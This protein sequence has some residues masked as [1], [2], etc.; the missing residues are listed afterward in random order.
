MIA[1]VDTNVLRGMALEN[2]PLRLRRSGAAEV[3]PVQVDPAQEHLA[4][5]EAL[6]LGFEEGLRQGRAEGV[7]AGR[8]EGL[9]Q[10]LAEARL[11][12][13]Q[14]AEDAVVEAQR[15]L[16]EER[17]QLRELTGSLERVFDDC[18]DKCE[19]EMLALCY[20]TICRMVGAAAIQPEL[21]RVQVAHLVS[22]C[23]AD[24]P[25]SILVHP[26]DAELLRSEEA[27]QNA[28]GRMH[29]I[30]DAEVPLGGCIVKSRAGSLDLR[31]ETMLSACKSSLLGVRAERARS[32]AAGARS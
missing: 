15:P 19:D 30:A 6:R 26:Q 23:K 25:L 1:R 27:V 12:A 3:V 16:A 5:Q 28:T 32:N 4:Q 18:L 14:L 31:L 9:R 20:E 11:Q 2:A 21:V 7:Q 22:L 8:E 13:Q 17:E 24:P 10:G 29:W